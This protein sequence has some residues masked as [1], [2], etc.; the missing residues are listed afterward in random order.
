MTATESRTECR[1]RYGNA[2][3]LAACMYPREEDLTSPSLPLLLPLRPGLSLFS[4]PPFALTLECDR[5][6]LLPLAGLLLDG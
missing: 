1:Q 6:S 4:L 3:S 5:R 2:A